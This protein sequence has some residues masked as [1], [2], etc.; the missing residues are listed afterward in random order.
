V[1]F[2]GI[3]LGGRAQR[4]PA[5]RKIDLAAMFPGFNAR[6]LPINLVKQHFLYLSAAD[7]KTDYSYFAT[8]CRAQRLS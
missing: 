8:I 3:D 2:A 1:A 5:M 7:R 6:R 4:G